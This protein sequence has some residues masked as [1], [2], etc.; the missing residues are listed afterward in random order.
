[1][2]GRQGGDEFEADVPGIRRSRLPNLNHAALERE[3]ALSG[4]YYFHRLPNGQEG[5][6]DLDPHAMQ[7]TIAP[8]SPAN[9]IAFRGAH[10]QLGGH[11][12]GHSHGTAFNWRGLCVHAKS[13]LLNVDQATMVR[14]FTLFVYQVNT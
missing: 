4:Q 5:V 12:V 9:V 1:V 6:A 3:P 2:L 14:I 8:N 11:L 7:R 13:K 10:Q